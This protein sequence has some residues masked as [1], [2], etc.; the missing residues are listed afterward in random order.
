MMNFEKIIFAGTPEFAVPSLQALVAN[1][2]PVTAVYTQ[3]DRPAGRGRKLQASPVKQAAGAIPVY[4]PESLKNP[5][6]QAELAALQADLMIVIA[7]GLILPQAVLDMPRHG[8]INVHASLLPR[9]RGAAP[10]QRALLAGD[11]E[12]GITIMRMEAGLDT[13]PM[14]QQA[15]CPILDEDTG[16]SLHDRLAELGARTLIESLRAWDNLQAQVQDDSLSTYARKLDKNEARL[17]WQNS[18]EQLARQVRAFN[19]WPVTQ[20]QVAGM[21]LRI[22]QA[23]A[24]A[25]SGD[26][27]VGSVVQASKDGIDIATGAG[28][29]RLLTV[30]KAGG[31]AIRAADFINAHPEFALCPQPR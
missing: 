29:L 3:P 26:A 13:G 5:Q 25:E 10:I 6:A 8:C 27:P 30:Q 17:D 28:V 19:P 1:G 12:T 24:L 2:Y 9:W 23:Q 11:R 14:L 18:A 21:E 31:R 16:A 22:W 15:V 7:Y 4:Q 20:A